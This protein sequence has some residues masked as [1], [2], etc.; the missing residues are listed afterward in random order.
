MIK[1]ENLTK[2]FGT[3]LA[4]ENLNLEISEGEG[5]PVEPGGGDGEE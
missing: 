2:K 5:A 4:V 3:T 1:T